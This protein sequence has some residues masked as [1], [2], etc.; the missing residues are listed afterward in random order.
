MLVFSFFYSVLNEIKWRWNSQCHIL[1]AN[2]QDKMGSA[3]KHPRLLPFWLECVEAIRLL[4]HFHTAFFSLPISSDKGTIFHMQHTT[5]VGITFNLFSVIF[6]LSLV[7]RL[8]TQFNDKLSIT[9]E[10]I[11]NEKK[12][13]LIA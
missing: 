11:P 13:P 6:F 9:I 7:D 10:M 1:Y 2:R 12:S 8:S 5:L 4:K 3:L